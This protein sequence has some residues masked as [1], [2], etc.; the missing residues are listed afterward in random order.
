MPYSTV[1]GLECYKWTTA[2]Y[3]IINNGGWKK[4]NERRMCVDVYNYVFAPDERSND[5]KCGSCWCCKPETLPVLNECENKPCGDPCSEGVCDGD[6]FC[7]SPEFN[8]CSVHGCDGKNCGDPCLSGDIQGVCNKDL[9][10]DF[11]VDSVISS[12]QCVANEGNFILGV[13]G[14]GVCPEG[15]QITDE[16]T[17]REACRTLNIPQAEILGYNKCYKD[18]HE[19]CYQNGHQGSGASMICKK[20][21]IISLTEPKSSPDCTDQKPWCRIADCNLSNVKENCPKKCNTC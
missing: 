8:P 21:E 7:V 10:C 16:T 4:E 3:E 18:R 9:E 19:K 5:R 12:G 6:G 13:K 20:S 11:D 17:C 2:D 14:S 15:T 1:L